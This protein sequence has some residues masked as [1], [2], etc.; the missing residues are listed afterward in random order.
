MN[1]A[2]FFMDLF[3]TFCEYSSSFFQGEVRP[4]WKLSFKSTKRREKIHEEH[5]INQKARIN[6]SYSKNL[7]Y[8][9][10]MLL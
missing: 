10:V 7:K 5:D 6:I 4:N 3:L 2:T 1:G 9:I 8:Q